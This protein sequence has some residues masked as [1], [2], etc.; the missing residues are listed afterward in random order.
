MDN[1]VF[2]SKHSDRSH[3][4][5]KAL[6][7][8]EWQEHSEKLKDTVRVAYF[9]VANFGF[10]IDYSLIEVN[11]VVL[12]EG[13]GVPLVAANVCPRVV[14]AGKQHA[15]MLA[16]QAIWLVIGPIVVSGHVAGVPPP[17][18]AV[19]APIAQTNPDIT[20]V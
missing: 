16:A 5:G 11:P 9:C 19:A 14:L 8:A 15:A 12:A 18:L 7:F 10:F 17:V 4:G 1:V 6:R 2:L 3:R 20:I 13:V